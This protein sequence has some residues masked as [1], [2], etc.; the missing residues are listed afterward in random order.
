MSKIVLLYAHRKQVI[1]FF[2][3]SLEGFLFSSYKF[4]NDRSHKKF[5]IKYFQ[6]GEK[7][8]KFLFHMLLK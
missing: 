7:I 1:R 3:K 6:K 2:D 5:Y 8:F 4:L